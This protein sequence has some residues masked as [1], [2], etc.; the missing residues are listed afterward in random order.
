MSKDWNG[1]NEGTASTA[2]TLPEGGDERA[3]FEKWCRDNGVH[4]TTDYATY[5]KCEKAW[6]DSQLYARAASTATVLAEQSAAPQAKLSEVQIEA[7]TYDEYAKRQDGESD[8]DCILKVVK[9]CMGFSN[10]PRN[11][12]GLTRAEFE[13]QLRVG[14]QHDNVRRKERG[15]PEM[16]VEAME[17][18]ITERVEL[19]YPTPKR[20]PGC[21]AFDNPETAEVD[22]VQGCEG[23]KARM[24]KIAGFGPLAATPLPRASGQ[25]DEA[26]T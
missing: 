18:E 16:T 25:A 24:Q 2:S 6:I 12:E 15:I 14:L 8:L 7:V 11:V 17:A 10:E 4:G 9:R 21:A 19:N 5:A 22:F 3:A 23:C 1:I 26:V 13:H 20:C